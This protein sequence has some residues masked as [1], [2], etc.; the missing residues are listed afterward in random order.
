MNLENV[1]SLTAILAHTGF[2]N[3]SYRLLQHI[4]CRPVQFILTE[5][6]VRESDCLTCQLHFERKGDEFAFTYY[7]AA[8]IREQS[9]PT[10]TINQVT[11]RNLEEKMSEINWRQAEPVSV[12]RLDDPLTWAREKAIEQ[13]IA[14][15]ARISATEEGKMYADILKVRFWSGTLLEELTGNL[16][17]IRAKL[18]VSQRFYIAGYNGITV[19]EALRFLQNRWLEKRLHTRKRGASDQSNE[20]APIEQEGAKKRR[21]SQRK[22]RV[23]RK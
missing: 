16:T 14:E 2:Q 22:V 8:L 4:C 9:M 15:L 6:L 13:V 18:E 3:L 5:R 11:L 23:K 12:F 1:S 7:D 10:L 19:D 20:D 21:L 17:A